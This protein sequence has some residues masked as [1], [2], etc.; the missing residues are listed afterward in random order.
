VWPS[1]T[2][3]K[4]E[5][6]KMS[7]KWRPSKSQKKAFA[8]KM[9]DPAEQAAYEARKDARLEKRR[10]TSSFDY[11]T[12]GGR[13]VPTQSQYEFCSQNEEKFVTPEEKEAFNQVTGGHAC[14]QAVHHDLIHV[15][16]EKIRE[17]CYAG[18]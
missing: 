17:V 6:I 1:K 15:V 2:L 5:R 10:S 8:L 9:Q 12:A 11:S 18:L 7:Y 4:K 13:F 16:N 3:K 14:N